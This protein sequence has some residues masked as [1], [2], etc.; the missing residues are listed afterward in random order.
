VLEICPD[1]QCDGP[2]WVVFTAPGEPEQAECGR[3]GRHFNV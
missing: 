1:C 3:C 2:H